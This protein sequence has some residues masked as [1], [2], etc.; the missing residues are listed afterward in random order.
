MTK[1]TNDQDFAAA[2]ARA[3]ARRLAEENL[4]PE[5]LAFLNTLKQRWFALGK[6]EDFA[7]VKRLFIDSRGKA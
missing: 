6:T 1:A 4:S 5:D 2:V 3:E 7:L